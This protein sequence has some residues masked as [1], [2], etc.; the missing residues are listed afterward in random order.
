MKKNN[1]QAA[2]GNAAV[3]RRTV[4]RTAAAGA[5]GGILAVPVGAA[6]EPDAQNGRM[7]PVYVDEEVI[8]EDVW[9]V[10][11]TDTD[12]S[13][14]S[15]R[16]HVEVARPAST[17]DED[18]QLPTIVQASPYYGGLKYDVEGYDMEVELYTPDGDSEGGSE[19]EVGATGV[20]SGTTITRTEEDLLEFT[21]RRDNTAVTGTASSIG[22]SPYEQEFLQQGY[23]WAYAASIGTERSTGCPTIGGSEEVAAMTAVVD[24]FNGRATAYDSPTGGAPVEADWTDGTTGMIGKSYNGTLPN[25]VASTG[26]EGLEAIVPI[27]AISSWY[28]YYRS[29]G[30]VINPGDPGNPGLT[31]GVGMDTRVLHDVILTRADP[32]P[33]ETT[34]SMLEAGQDRLT[35]DYNEFWADRDYVLDAGNVDAAVLVTH[36]LTD[37]NVKPRNAS[38]WLESLVEHDVPRKVWL[39]RGAHIDP[40]RQDEMREDWLDLLNRWWAHWLH[41]EDNGVMDDPIATVQRER[42]SLRTYPDWPDP[43]AAPVSLR[44]SRDGSTIGGLGFVRTSDPIEDTLVDNSNVPPSYLATAPQSKH[45]LAYRTNPLRNPLRLSGTGRADLRLSIDSSAAIVSVALVRYPADGEPTHVSR[46]WA[47]PQNRESLE[48]SLPIEPHEDY[49]IAFDLQPVDTALQPGDRLG[50]LIY[51]SDFDFTKR[52]PSTPAIELTTPR[53]SVS[54]PIVGG[55][56]A[57]LKAI[58]E[59][60]ASHQGGLD[61]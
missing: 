43:R 5:G 14:D 21:G 2:E 10:T 60:S 15:D 32:E 36:G 16:V 56:E 13:G 51:S 23:C 1:R 50:V 26:V 8:R 6:T 38:R 9:V 34:R 20:E 40:I 28:S 49:R 18:V 4:I 61:R 46:S 52:P 57:A 35:G 30:T 41:G 55:R 7:R 39:M 48:Q 11:G 3:S 24:W 47:D 19:T 53:S 58:P 44:F 31:N 33:C 45:R 54:L 59:L 22:P 27:A 12:N 37:W 42:G 25:G 29:H 17:T